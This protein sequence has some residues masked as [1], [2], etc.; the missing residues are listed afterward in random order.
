[1][2]KCRTRAVGWSTVFCLVIR[3]DDWEVKHMH[4]SSCTGQPYL[5]Q[6]ELQ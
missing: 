6:I 5:D 4:V 2:R 3:K 1:M